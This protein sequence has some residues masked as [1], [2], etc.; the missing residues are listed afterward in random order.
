[1]IG[2]ITSP[3]LLA[4]FKAN[5]YETKKIR[6]LFFRLGRGVYAEGRMQ[7]IEQELKHA[8]QESANQLRKMEMA[9]QESANQL[10]EMEMVQQESDD[11]LREMERLAQRLDSAERLHQASEK[12]RLEIEPF[13]REYVSLINSRTWKA[14]QLGWRVR[15]RV[16]PPSSM[17]ARVSKKLLRAAWQT[18]KKIKGNT[19]T[20]AADDQSEPPAGT[21]F[22]YGDWVRRREPDAAQLEAQALAA[23][24]YEYRPLVSILTP[25]YRTPLPVLRMAIESVLRQ[26]YDNWELCLVDGGSGQAELQSLLE[27]YASRD[28]RIRVRHLIQNLGIAENTNEALRMAAGDFIALLDHDD[29]LAPHALFEYVARLNYDQAIDVFYSDEDKLDEQGK[30]CH[31]FFKPDWSPEYFRGVMYVGHLLCFRRSLVERTDGFDPA[32]D[33]VQDFEFMLRLSEATMRIQH[34]PKL[35]YHWRQ[36]PGSIAQDGQAKPQI[37][38]LQCAAVNAHLARIGLPAK[39]EIASPHHRVCTLPVPI[40][41]AAAKVSIIIP[42]KDAPE[43]LEKCLMTI[44]ERSSYGNYEVVLVD[45]DTSDA[46]ALAVMKRFPIRRVEFPGKFN[47]S[48]A[49]NAGVRHASGEYL[50]FLN[51]DTEVVAPDWIEHL[52]YYGAQADV[53]AVGALL[54]YPD[55]TVQHAGVI[56]GPR[57]TA[58]HVL[59]GA[60]E[61][62]DGY[63]GSLLCAHEV[64]AATAACLLMKRADFDALGGFSEHYFTHYQDIDLCLRVRQMGKRIIYAPRAELIHYESKTR[65]DNYDFVDR[66]LLLDQWQDVIESGDPYYNPNFDPAKTDYSLRR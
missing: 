59:R 49:N 37:S 2:E 1:A 43:Y 30:R 53:G 46:R 14:M 34:V 60:R 51:N 5:E 62:M 25:V 4:M 19:P 38:E 52:V 24:G 56:L 28:G 9:Q 40:N 11:R 23:R 17:R 66:V 3:D 35:L 36:S 21:D 48:R 57:G 42:S 47:Y 8:Q 27:D 29:E 16:A 13:A 41:V 39:A 50:L 18:I 64:S 7:R 58:D 20:V 55:R 22:D 63:G 10:R 33:G 54:L 65:K 44:F 26:S 45:N 32:Y 12:R 31:P 15:T 61:G 6:D